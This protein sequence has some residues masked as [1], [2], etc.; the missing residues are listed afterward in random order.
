MQVEVSSVGPGAYQLSDRKMRWGGTGKAPD[1]SVL[2]VTDY[3][4]LRGIPEAAHNY[5]VNGRTPLEWAVDRLHIRQDQ[6]AASST[7]PT[8]GSRTIRRVWS[9]TCGGWCR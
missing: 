9:R 8:P 1:R 4:T 2:H 3:V 7:T 5:V 6:R